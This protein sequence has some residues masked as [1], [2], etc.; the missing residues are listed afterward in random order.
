LPQAAGYYTLR[1]AGV[2]KKQNASDVKR[3][4]KQNLDS[5]VKPGND[6]GDGHDK[7]GKT[8]NGFPFLKLRKG[9]QAMPDAPFFMHC[10]F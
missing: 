9:L 3:I 10:N 1:V 5:P 6:S 4:G 8:K 2:T 7:E